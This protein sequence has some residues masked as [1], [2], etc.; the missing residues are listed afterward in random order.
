VLTFVEDSPFTLHVQTS[1]RNTISPQPSKT[2]LHPTSRSSPRQKS[3]LPRTIKTPKW[4]QSQFYDGDDDD[5]PPP[6]SHVDSGSN[7]RLPL[8]PRD[9]NG[10]S[11]LRRKGYKSRARLPSQKQQSQIQASYERRRRLEGEDV[12]PSTCWPGLAGTAILGVTLLV[13]TML[14]VGFVFQTSRSLEGVVI[15]NLTNIVVSQE[16]LVMDLIVDAGNPNILPVLM[17]DTINIDIFA[18]SDHMDDKP[19]HHPRRTTRFTTPPFWPPW[20]DDD[21]DKPTRDRSAPPKNLTDGPSLLLGTIRSLEAPLSFPPTGFKRVPWTVQKGQMKLVGPAT[22][23]TDGVE[24][25]KKCIAEDFELIVRG[26]MKYRA[27]IGGRDR[28]VAVEWRGVVDPLGN[29]IW[30]GEVWVEAEY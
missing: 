22:N 14:T 3:T 25:W 10:R 7:E 21:D 16:E 4:A 8:L 29:R 30:N 12:G 11:S 1:S 5:Y 28:V 15:R 2:A 20:G 9:L 17:G 23:A 6:T 18:R 13:L 19:G 24:K 27:P 26:T